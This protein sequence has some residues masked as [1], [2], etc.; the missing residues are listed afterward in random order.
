M[1]RLTDF[2]T[3]VFRRINAHSYNRGL[4]SSPDQASDVVRRV[5]NPGEIG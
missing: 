4:F 2:A 5:E 3:S 1:G